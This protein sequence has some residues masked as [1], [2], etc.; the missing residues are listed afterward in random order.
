V[1]GKPVS[2]LLQFNRLLCS[3]EKEMAKLSLRRNGEQ[4]LAFV[5]LMPFE[6][7]LRKK[8]GLTLKEPQT[9]SGEAAPPWAGQGLFVEEVEK[10]SPGEEAGFQKGYLV[11]G[12]DGNSTIELR[13]AGELLAA[14]KRGQ[15]TQLS[16]IVPRRVG[17]YVQFRQAVVNVKIR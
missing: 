3:S 11:A 9:T 7:L 16:V 10:G 13:T 5:K 15:A 2:S 14:K 8:L 6:D 17:N 1:N 4:I 12:V